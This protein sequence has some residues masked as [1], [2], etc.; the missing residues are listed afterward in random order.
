M[1]PLKTKQSEGKLIPYSDL[2][3]E[4]VFLGETSRRRKR[5]MKIGTWN[6]RSFYRAGSLKEAAREL[7]WYK[8]DVVGVRGSQVGKR[9]HSNS[10]GYDFFYGKGNEN[11]QLGTGC[12]V[13][14]RIVS[15][16]V[17]FVSDRLSYIVLGGCWRNTFVVNVHA[18]S[19]EK[20]DTSKDS[21]YADLE[22]MTI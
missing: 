2:R 4:G 17:E 14:R 9:G 10:T 12:F 20:S 15:T 18:P 13:H 7:V 19:K 8:I 22:H 1:L 21:F 16:V 5:G 11:H 3:V 6:C